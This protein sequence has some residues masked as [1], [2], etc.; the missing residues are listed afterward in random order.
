M[1]TF[2]LAFFLSSNKTKPLI[3]FWKKVGFFF[4][5][6]P[7]PIYFSYHQVHK[8][9]VG[10]FFIQ[11]EISKYLIAYRAQ[12]KDDPGSSSF[13]AWTTMKSCAASEA[14]QDLNLSLW[15]PRTSMLIHSVEEH[16]VPKSLSIISITL[17]VQNVTTKKLITSY[18]LPGPSQLELY[19]N[20]S[21][22]FKI[23]SWIKDRFSLTKEKKNSC[24]VISIK[25]EKI[26]HL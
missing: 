4:Y 22:D 5:F 2:K 15:Q 8:I 1:I 18:I 17:L 16:F 13:S 23:S 19:Y 9:E 26:Q 6:Y 20:H 11:K 14:E 12:D 10:I 3:Q 25:T 21:W 7:I 24:F